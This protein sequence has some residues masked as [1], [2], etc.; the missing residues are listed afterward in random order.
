MN[1]PLLR[2]G[3]SQYSSVWETGHCPTLCVRSYHHWLAL[4][5]SKVGVHA[6][7]GLI[8]VACVPA[9]TLKYDVPN[10]SAF[11]LLNVIRP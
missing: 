4:G 1:S 10:L 7:L 11:A 3:E 6:F 8:L 9:Y 2:T 5:M